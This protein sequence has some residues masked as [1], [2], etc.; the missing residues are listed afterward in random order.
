MSLE[1]TATHGRKSETVIDLSIGEQ[2]NIAFCM[3]S[4]NAPVY[5]SVTNDFSVFTNYIGIRF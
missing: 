5:K 1:H 4:L 3:L 2:K